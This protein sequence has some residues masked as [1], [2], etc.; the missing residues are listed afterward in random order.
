VQAEAHPD[1]DTLTSYVERSLQAAERNRVLGHLAACSQCRDIVSLSLVEPSEAVTAQGIGASAI[2]WWRQRWAP[3]LGLAASLATVAVIAAIVVELPTRKSH[4]ASEE[5]A[6]VENHDVVPGEISTPAAASPQPSGTSQPS[7]SL[8]E[9][10]RPL[11]SNG[12]GVGAG[13]RTMPRD[14]VAGNARMASAG[15]VSANAKDL[16][17]AS[18][19]AQ[20]VVV[21]GAMYAVEASSAPGRRQDYLNDQFFSTDGAANGSSVTDLPA[22]PAA[23]AA[24]QFQLQNSLASGSIAFSNLPV[25]TQQNTKVLVIRKPPS[26]THF[27]ITVLDQIQLGFRKATPAIR[28]NVTSAFAM[29]GQELNPLREKG[30]NGEL[31]AAAPP[32]DTYRGDL[33][34]SS[35][36]SPRAMS[37]KYEKKAETSTASWKVDGGKLLKFSDSGAWMEAYPGSEGVDFSVVKSH[38]SDIWA[39]GNNAALLHSRDGGATWERITLGASATGTIAAIEARGANILVKSSSGQSWSSQDGGKSWTL[40][41]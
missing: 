12:A 18:S 11:R 24:N 27:P 15:R 25:Q 7:A 17:A 2:P 6:K 38:G 22:A 1:A 20:P 14:E 31:S 3:R 16:G 39:G 21:T 33:D 19:P 23:K 5:K 34:R 9:G 37:D 41:N 28:P 35:A 36:F 4:T 29:S 30:D 13:M 8:A 26:R 40:L 32:P 10:E